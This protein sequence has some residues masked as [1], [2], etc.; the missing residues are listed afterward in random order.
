LRPS[1]QFIAGIK[2]RGIIA[3]RVYQKKHILRT[4]AGNRDG[5]D[6]GAHKG[7]QCQ[8]EREDALEQRIVIPGKQA[9]VGTNSIQSELGVG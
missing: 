8:R 6:E 2:M 3:V 4:A 5:R 1:I 9:A 7:E